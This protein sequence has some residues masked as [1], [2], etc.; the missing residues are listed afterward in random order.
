MAV[1]SLRTA[2][3]FEVAV[4]VSRIRYDDDD[5]LCL[6]LSFE[7]AF[8]VIPSNKAL[9]LYHTVYSATSYALLK[10]TEGGHS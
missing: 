5:D 8:A 9:L 6:L 7:L 3:E 2:K 4:N 1:V 10:T